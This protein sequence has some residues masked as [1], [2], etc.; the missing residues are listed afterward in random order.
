M[1]SM[2]WNHNFTHHFYRR[3]DQHI[4]LEEAWHNAPSPD[5]QTH[6]VFADREICPKC[7]ETYLRICLPYSP[8]CFALGQM[9]KVA[10]H[11]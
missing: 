8:K 2:S 7:V 11:S 9:P 5:T 1:N 6:A 4:V 3:T 10:T